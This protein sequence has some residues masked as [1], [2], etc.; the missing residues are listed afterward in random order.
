MAFLVEGGRWLL[1]RLVPELRE[2]EKPSPYDDF[3]E[4]QEHLE[5]FPSLESVPKFY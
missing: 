2:D 4:L 3:P 5:R 1:S